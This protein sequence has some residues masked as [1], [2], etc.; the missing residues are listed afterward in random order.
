MRGQRGI[1]LVALVVTIVVLLILAGITITYVLSDGGIFGKAQEAVE[2]QEIAALR[3]YM[4]LSMVDAKT[5]HYAPTAGTA[6]DVS[7]ILSANFP[8]TYCT[9]GAT[10]GVTADAKGNLT[11]SVDVTVVKSSNVYTVN[12]TNKDVTKKAQPG[13]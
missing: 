12:F 13:G 1:T 5:E 6:R 2:S 9:L 8:S 7:A 11:G 4:G 10:T 3:D